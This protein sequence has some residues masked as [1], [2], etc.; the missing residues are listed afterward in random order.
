[1]FN[2]SAQCAYYS[3]VVHHHE[4]LMRGRPRG[5]AAADLKIYFFCSCPQVVVLRFSLPDWLVQLQTEYLLPLII[6]F[7]DVDF[8]AQSLQFVL[9]ILGF[10]WNIPFIHENTKSNVWRLGSNKPSNVWIHMSKFLWLMNRLN[11]YLTHCWK[12]VTDAL[13]AEEFWPLYILPS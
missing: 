4:T 8:T 12:A 3:L 9:W 7:R 1:M 11:W 2:C 5:T 6:A 10:P 13:L